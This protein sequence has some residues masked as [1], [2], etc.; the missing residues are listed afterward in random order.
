MNGLDAI[1]ELRAA[2]KEGRVKKRY[3]VIAVVS[4]TTFDYHHLHWH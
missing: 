2:E 3:P 4:F 1:T